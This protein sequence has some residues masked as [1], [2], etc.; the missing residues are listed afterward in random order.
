M[1]DFVSRVMYLHSAV[2]I[3]N[4]ISVEMSV[5][6]SYAETTNKSIDDTNCK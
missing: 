1:V 5:S 4:D 3:S 6:P 2:A